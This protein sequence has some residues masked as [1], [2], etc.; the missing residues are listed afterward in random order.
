MTNE[1][2]ITFKKLLI[3]DTWTWRTTFDGAVRGLCWEGVKE[4]VDLPEDCMEFEAVFSEEG[5]SNLTGYEIIMNDDTGYVGLDLNQDPDF[6]AETEHFLRAMYNSG[7]HY[8][9]V[10]YEHVG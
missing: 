4:Y 1:T 7:Y 3:N 9:H 5:P 6:F 10:E 8:L 2:R